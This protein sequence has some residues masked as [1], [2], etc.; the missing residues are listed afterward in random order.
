MNHILD[1]LET[2]A[3]NELIN[4]SFAEVRE[5]FN[6]FIHYVPFAKENDFI[7]EAAQIKSWYE[8]ELNKIEAYAR[9]EFASLFNAG[10]DIAEYDTPQ[11]MVKDVEL[12]TKSQLI[13]MIKKYFDRELFK[14]DKPQLYQFYN[15]QAGEEKTTEALHELLISLNLNKDK[16]YSLLS[17]LGHYQYHNH[18]FF[19]WFDRKKIKYEYSAQVCWLN[20]YLG[21]EYREVDIFFADRR[22]KLSKHNR[23]LGIPE[24]YQSDDFIDIDKF[25][26]IALI[27][28]YL[29]HNTREI[30]KIIEIMRKNLGGGHNGADAWSDTLEEVKK[31]ITECES[32]GIMKRL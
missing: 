15:Q 20:R 11:F 25:S 28:P 8:G 30:C 1:C 31:F 3:F 13:G 29:K 9:T 12:Q 21:M 32:K 19:S 17:I 4:F 16:I 24:T 23:D 7:N 26:L 18:Y 27:Q 5:L 22:L 14:S 6:Q 2:E 10:E